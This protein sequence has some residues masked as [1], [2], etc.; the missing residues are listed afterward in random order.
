MGIW[1][2]HSTYRSVIVNVHEF[3]S[4]TQASFN[5]FMIDCPCIQSVILT[6]QLIAGNLLSQGI[7]KSYL[8]ESTQ[9]KIAIV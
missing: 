9:R 6:V 8:L 1:G 5:D 4:R 7:D 2:G 3:C